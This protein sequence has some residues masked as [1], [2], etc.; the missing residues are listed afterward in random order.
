MAESLNGTFALLIFVTVA[1]T[2]LSIGLVSSV[3]LL[4][5]ALRRRGVAVVV[6]LNCVAVP[7]LAYL[8]TLALSLTP[9]A[10]T[11]ILICAICAGG[12]LGL[13]ATQVARGD[14]TWS[15]S[16]TVVLL[17]LNVVTLPLW[18]SLLIDGP[19]TL[20]MGDLLGVL[21][22]AILVPVAVGMV[23][24]PRVPD[25]DRW[26]GFLSKASNALLVLAVTLGVA[27]NAGGLVDSLSSS[28]LL[29]VVAVVVVAGGVEWLVPDEMGR[30]RASTLGTLNR[31]TSV[32]LLIVGRVFLDQTEIFTT[33]VLFG[34]IQTVIAIG[35]ALYW[36]VAQSTSTAPAT[37]T[38]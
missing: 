19:V 21:G 22:A 7:L 10:K 34:L 25:I 4:G 37:A 5:S 35:L 32:A 30:R 28:L 1:L 31:A 2:A 24:R 18:S 11:G 33:V 3:E 20:R 9:G 13:K 38:T 26:F 27:A 16:M 8:L 17:V 15:L 14:L 36:G 6:L 12:P 29:A 23:L